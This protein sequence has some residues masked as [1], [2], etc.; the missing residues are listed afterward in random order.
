M[1]GMAYMKTLLFQPFSGMDFKMIQDI[2]E[3]ERILLRFETNKNDIN[4]LTG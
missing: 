2:G 1:P 4:F 3:I